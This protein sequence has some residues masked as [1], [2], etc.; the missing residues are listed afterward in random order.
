V[1]VRDPLFSWGFR[2]H[3]IFPHPRSHKFESLTRMG[4]YPYKVRTDW[5]DSKF[6]ASLPIHLCTVPEDISDVWAD[7][8]LISSQE[9][10]TWEQVHKHFLFYFILTQMKEFQ[11]KEEEEQGA[12]PH[13][14]SPGSQAFFRWSPRL[15][16]SQESHHMQSTSAIL[17]KF[18]HP[19]SRWSSEHLCQVILWKFGHLDHWGSVSTISTTCWKFMHTGKIV[20]ISLGLNRTF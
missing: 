8:R 20:V 17:W 16:R 2:I 4:K 1:N 13:R 18:G 9:V 15:T 14:I 3:E 7:L 19:S 12:I 6:K 11:C 10:G 5:E